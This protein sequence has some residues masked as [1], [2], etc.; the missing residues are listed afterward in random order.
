MIEI[1]DRGQG[2]S[3]D[4]YYWRARSPN[5]KIVCSAKSFNTRR[6]ALIGIKA[7]KKLLSQMDDIRDYVE[8]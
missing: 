8:E 5:G 7:A 4:R 3:K 6:N 1:I 2:Y